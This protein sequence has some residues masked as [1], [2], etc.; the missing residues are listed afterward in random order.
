METKIEE[1][2]NKLASFKR[3][4]MKRYYIPSFDVC[5]TEGVKYM[6]DAC[7]ADRLIAVIG[8]HCTDLAQKNDF[9]KVKFIKNDDNSV[10]ILYQGGVDNDLKTEQIHD[11]EFPLKEINFFFI[12]DTLLL[13][14]EY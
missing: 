9:I 11:I 1:I 3:G 8:L 5:Y 13:T 4:K 10:E 6:A 7:N 12:Y 2:K 14:S